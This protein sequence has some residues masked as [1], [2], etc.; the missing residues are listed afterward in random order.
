[1]RG[2]ARPVLRTVA[3]SLAALVLVAACSGRDSSRSRSTAPIPAEAFSFV[4]VGTRC[5]EL[6]RMVGALVAPEVGTPEEAGIPIGSSS[7]ATVDYGLFSEEQVSCSIPFRE[8]RLLIAV[9]RAEG[10]R[11]APRE[12]RSLW[13]GEMVVE[14]RPVDDRRRLVR[15][16]EP[17]RGEEPRRVSGVGERATWLAGDDV[18]DVREARL[19]VLV[20]SSHGM[21][22][23]AEEPPD[24]D[25]ILGRPE[26]LARIAASLI[27][28][29]DLP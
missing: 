4:E 21:I 18:T 17:T 6:A 23:S 8:R 2:A 24:K 9:R 22:L 13:S 5:D 28:A 10:G 19:L 7:P 16:P 29:L 26:T 1:M 25:P 20:D 12:L 14:A 3:A 11:Q 27:R 15:R